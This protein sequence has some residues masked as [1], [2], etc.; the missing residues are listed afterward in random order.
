MQ[1]AVIEYARNVCKL[2]KAGSSEFENKLESKV[3][4]IMNDQK[5]IKNK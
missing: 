4:D 1:V 5:N 3:I 2:K